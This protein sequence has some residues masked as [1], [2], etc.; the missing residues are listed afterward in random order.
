MAKAK[1]KHVHVS[2]GDYWVKVEVDGKVIHE[3][4]SLDRDGG[5]EALVTALGGTYSESFTEEEGAIA[6][7]A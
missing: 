6:E 7:G 4:H 3:H 2:H 1:K 5:I